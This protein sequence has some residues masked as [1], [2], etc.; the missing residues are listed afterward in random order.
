M[1]AI[2]A[3]QNEPHI[4][5]LMDSM[6]HQGIL[7]KETCAL[8]AYENFEAQVI[9]NNEIRVRSGVGSI[10]GR[11]FC[12]EPNTYDAVT[13]NN[14]S[15]GEKRKDLIVV[16]FEENT[17]TKVQTI[18]LRV[19]QGQ[20]SESTPA[21]PEYTEGNLDD[22]DIIAEVPWLEVD[23]EG[24]NIVGVKKV[25]ELANRL[26]DFEVL[27]SDELIQECIDAGLLTESEVGGGSA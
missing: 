11:F 3:I 20:P 2:T 22:G 6:W 5:P 18:D 26:S 19:I 12:I 4:T 15:Q 10:Q 14:G 7:G 17:D 24:I 13:I 9:S 21:V 1:K 16:H 27:I 8:N 25:F 23:L